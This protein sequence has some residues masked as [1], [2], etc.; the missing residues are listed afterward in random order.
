MADYQRAVQ[1]YETDKMGIVHHSNYIRYFEEARTYFM[2]INGI[3]YAKMEE[4]GLMLPVIEVDCKYKT[5][6]TY[7]QIVVVETEITDCNGITLSFSYTIREKESG[8]ICTEGKSKH[9]FVDMNFKPV[10]LQKIAP[11]IYEKICAIKKA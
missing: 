11:E 9:C 3:N 7:G 4:K 5:G 1:Y 2:D 8:K 10:K 6:A